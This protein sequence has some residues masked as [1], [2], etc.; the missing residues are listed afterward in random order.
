M[1]LRL[2]LLLLIVS[3]PFNNS[4]LSE[5]LTNEKVL[6]VIAAQSAF[7]HLF[8]FLIGISLYMNAIS[9]SSSVV[10]V[11]TLLIESADLGKVMVDSSTVVCF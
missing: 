3:P 10:V 5:L 11:F 4:D 8:K 1:L 2:F 7:V 6:K 9:M